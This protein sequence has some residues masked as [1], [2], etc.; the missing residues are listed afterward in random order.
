MGREDERALT[1]FGY[2]ESRENSR[3]VKRVYEGQS[4]LNPV[5]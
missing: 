3:T 4:K 5:N 2:I 1:C